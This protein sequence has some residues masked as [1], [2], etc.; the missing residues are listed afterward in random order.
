MVNAEV[1]VEIDGTKPNDTK[2]E[3]AIEKR[4]DIRQKNYDF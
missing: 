4:C 3:N 1:Q 2:R